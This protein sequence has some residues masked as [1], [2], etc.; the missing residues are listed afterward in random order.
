VKARVAIFDQHADLQVRVL[1]A[2]DRALSEA[3]V[4]FC[5]RE[6]EVPPDAARWALAEGAIVSLLVFGLKVLG[7][8][9]AYE[10]TI[11]MFTDALVAI[12]KGETTPL[13]E[14]PDEVQKEPKP[15]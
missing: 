8:E 1:K 5:L 2:L 11:M 7:E 12:E 14:F 6:G 9:K 10:R 15:S 3:V 13:S 4:D